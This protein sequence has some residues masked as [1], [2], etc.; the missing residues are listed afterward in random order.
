M[1]YTFVNAK[2]DAEAAGGSCDWQYDQSLDNRSASG[3]SVVNRG[4]CHALVI[5]WI[6][7][8]FAGVNFLAWFA[9][10]GN[11]CP[12]RAGQNGA[13][14]PVFVTLKSMMEEQS[15]LLDRFNSQADRSWWAVDYALVKNVSQYG[16]TP[17]KDGVRGFE[18]NKNTTLMVTMITEAV[19]YNYIRLGDNNQSGHAVGVY[20][21]AD[22]TSIVFFDPNFGQFR[23]ASEATF[24]A[25]LKAFMPKSG[26]G[27]TYLRMGVLHITGVN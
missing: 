23:F 13:V 4:W 14:G 6:K 26:Y 8:N 3:G 22:K 1:P 17:G 19:G 15:R 2:T 7:Q 10:S 12:Q 21:S 20:V 16:L 18:I 27:K 11:A 5:M 24:Q 9:P 25:F